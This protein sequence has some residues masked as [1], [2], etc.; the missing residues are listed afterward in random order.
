M[1]AVREEGTPDRG[2]LVAAL[3]FVEGVGAGWE[4]KDLSAWF[5]DEMVGPGRMTPVGTVTEAVVGSI[6]LDPATSA[7]GERVATLNDLPKLLAISR[8]RVVVTLRGFIANTPNDRFLQAAIY[9][10]RVERLRVGSEAVWIARPKERELLS[11]IVLSLF[12]VDMLMHR[13]FHERSL[14]VCDACGRV[15]FNP[16]TT[17]RT[18]CPEH[19][20]GG[21]PPNGLLRTASQTGFKPPV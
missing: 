6:A 11:D 18:G 1:R 19:P 4:L 13:D 3:R 7:V 12:A 17:T 9:A 10:G 20:S 16:G 21:T 5:A 2:A 15:S 14:C 8:S